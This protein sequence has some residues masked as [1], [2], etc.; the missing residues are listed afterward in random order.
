MAQARPGVFRFGAIGAVV[1]V[2]LGLI[3]LI[4]HKVD[5]FTCPGG[6]SEGACAFA[7][8]LAI[9]L[10]PRAIAVIAMLG[11]F[12]AARPSALSFLWRAEANEPRSRLWPALN[13]IGLALILLPLLF[14]SP[15][16]AVPWSVLVIWAAGA[17]LA[18]GGAVFWAAPPVAWARALRREGA[19][20]LAAVA[21][22]FFVFDAATL[23]QPMM[24][25]ALPALTLSTSAAILEAVGETVTVDPSTFLLGAGD[26][27]VH[28][29]APCSGIEGIVLISAFMGAYLAL[30]RREL[31]LPHALVLLPLG[32]IVSWGFNAVRI[33]VLI[34]IG[35][36]IS[37]ELAID[38][39]HT[40]AGWLS[41]TIIALTLA[42]FAHATPWLRR[43]PAG[44]AAVTSRPIAPPL[45][46]DWNAALI[47]PFV[48]FMGSSLV[49]STFAEIPA[50]LY[51]ARAAAMAVALLFFWRLYARLDWRIDPLAAL[52]GAV[53][54]VLW[55]VTQ[56]APTGTDDALAGALAAMSGA[57]FAVW[58]A[59]R[60]IG[61]TL[62]VPAIE[63]LFFRGYLLR[64]FGASPEMT[65]LGL[66][67]SS[68]LF[69]VLHDRWL[70]ALLA[71]LLFGALTLRRGRV[72][73]AFA[74]H[75][76]ANGVIAAWAVAS[77]DWAVI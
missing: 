27:A 49:A 57:G 63:E 41:F 10:V 45:R 20:L 64:R 55:I 73:D 56:P 68:A 34:W 12:A 42:T 29:G 28:V 16:G 31:R 18:A 15:G 4:Q 35:E 52:V 6:D 70:A 75:A 39:F 53:V 5:P 38:A 51:P 76:A 2:E 67:I 43:A 60:I 36:H 62:L 33:A 17:L 21:A 74:A 37:P 71:G 24:W 48:V 25:E 61:T 19:P 8:L 11:L 54:G 1:V 46:E 9:S 40:Y 14:L 77:G 32:V 50:L 47:L 13:V 3:A 59:T 69:A 22:G 26:F 30:F 23:L 66:A 7:L 58:A 44:G 72:T 65:L